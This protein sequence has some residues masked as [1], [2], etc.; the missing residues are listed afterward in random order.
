MCSPWTFKCSTFHISTNIKSGLNRVS[1]PQNNANTLIAQS[2]QQ[3]SPMHVTF[4]QTTS[5]TK[6]KCCL[7]VRLSS[8]LFDFALPYS[9][10][11]LVDIS[12]T[13]VSWGTISN[14]FSGS[15]LH[16]YLIWKKKMVIQNILKVAF[17]RN[18]VI[19]LYTY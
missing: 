2:F 18:D 4:G 10:I 3:K 15:K 1:W 7:L 19:L 9:S 6:K 12:N 5:L 17:V 11:L 13:Y 8:F 14:L 16:M